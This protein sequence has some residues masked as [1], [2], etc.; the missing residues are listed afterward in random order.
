MEQLSPFKNFEI[1]KR[2]GLG[3]MTSN[4]S[5]ILTV[6]TIEDLTQGIE[7]SFTASGNREPGLSVGR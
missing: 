1:S 6:K 5:Q 7:W 4:T 2:F 3:W